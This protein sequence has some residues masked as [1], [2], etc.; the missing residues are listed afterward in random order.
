MREFFVLFI[1]LSSLL[2]SAIVHADFGVGKYEKVPR[3]M[4]LGLSYSFVD[5]KVN[6]NDGDSTSFDS[7]LLG[8]TIGYQ[9][10]TNFSVEFRGYG[11]ISDDEISNTTV[12]V[13]NNFSLMG[14]ALLPLD[15]NFKIYALLGYGKAKGKLGGQSETENEV[16]YGVGMAVNEGHPVDLEVEWVKL[17]DDNFNLSGVNFSGESINI[18]LVYHFP[19]T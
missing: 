16:Q 4:Y 14:R 13:S 2:H 5:V 9:A 1:Y 8:L 17:F 15:E 12:E 10:H 19:G 11:N 3:H 7:S 18:N 6:I